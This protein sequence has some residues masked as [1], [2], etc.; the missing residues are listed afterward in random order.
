MERIPP[1]SASP[2]KKLSNPYASTA[3]KLA[4]WQHGEAAKLDLSLRN[5][6]LDNQEKATHKRRPMSPR[7]KLKHIDDSKLEEQTSRRGGVHLDDSESHI[8]AGRKCNTNETGGLLGAVAGKPSTATHRGV[9][10]ENRNS[11]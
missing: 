9:R 5:P 8:N 3:E 6:Q 1:G 11:S 2:Q 4:T 10:M 7:K